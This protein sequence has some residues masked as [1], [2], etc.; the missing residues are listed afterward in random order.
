MVLAGE[1]GRIDIFPATS[2][3]DVGE[4][5]KFLRDSNHDYKWYAI[6][7][8]T[9]TQEL[10]KRKAL[11]ERDLSAD[12]HMVTM[13]DWGKIGELQGELFYRFRMLPMH[14][15]FLA[16]ERLRGSGE[17]GA[18]EYQPDISPAALSKL[19][20]SMF[21]VGRLFTREVEEP[22]TKQL[23][24]ERR[25]RVGPHMHTVTKVRALPERPMP[26]V[27]RE[28]QLG[29]ILAWLIGAKS[30]KAP[31]S[32]AADDDGLFEATG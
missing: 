22:E 14:G 1:A 12:P 11:R 4:A 16:Q 5:Y 32:V 10:A 2:W 7:T 9:A 28:P 17:D 23:V 25:L 6:D 24:I 20:P 21:L 3:D 29:Q 15:I 8:V 30:A 31:Q 18:M 27:V 13:Q 19:S 26:A